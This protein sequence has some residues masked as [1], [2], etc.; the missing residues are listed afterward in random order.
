MPS[1]EAP[2][3]APVQVGANA[4]MREAA[5]ITAEEMMTSGFRRPIRSLSLPPT[6]LVTITMTA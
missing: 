1:T 2:I 4:R 6:T 3:S 5:A